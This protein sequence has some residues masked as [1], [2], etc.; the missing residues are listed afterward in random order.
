MHCYSLR[1]RKSPH[2]KNYGSF[3]AFV[4]F[5]FEV[6]LDHFRVCRHKG[7]RSL[8]ILEVT[9]KSLF[10]RATSFLIITVWEHRDQT[11]KTEIETKFTAEL[12]CL[13]GSG[14]NAVDSV[15]KVLDTSL[16]QWNL[17]SGNKSL[18]GF[19]IS[20]AVFRIPSASWA[21]DSEP[22]RARG[23]IV[24]KPIKQ[25]LFLFTCCAENYAVVVLMRICK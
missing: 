3:A 10:N 4:V 13:P 6:I 12:I 20:W 25:L 1:F 16:H 19:R 17:E 2:F 21:I 14:F 9:I 11:W 7:T 22:I 18:V 5:M 15:F 8:N 24:K 23:I